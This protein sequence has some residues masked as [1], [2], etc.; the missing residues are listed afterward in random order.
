[1]CFPE[2]FDKMSTKVQ[3]IKRKIKTARAY[4]SS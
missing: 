4:G 3:I 2:I 1:M